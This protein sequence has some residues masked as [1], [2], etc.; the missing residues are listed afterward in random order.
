MTAGPR[1][2]DPSSETD[3]AAPEQTSWAWYALAAGLAL[4]HA[5]LAVRI[6]NGGLG[7]PISYDGDGVAV[8]A[9]A[10]TAARQGWYEFEPHLGWPHGQTYHDFPTAENLHMAVFAVL[11]KLWQ[12]VT[13]VNVYFLAGFALAAPLALRLFRAI[14]L[15]PIM[16]TVM[17]VL[18]ATAA[19][20]YWRGIPHLFLA[21]YWVL[22]PA[23]LVVWRSAR[24]EP[25]WR[26]APGRYGKWRPVSTVAAFVLLGIA[27]TYYSVFVGAL[28][29]IAAVACLVQR[30]GWR[31][32]LSPLVAGLVLVAVMLA[33]M[34]TDIAYARSL[35]ANPVG[36]TRSAGDVE[37]FGLRLT[38]L[39]LPT[40]DHWFGPARRL[41]D[42]FFRTIPIP[43]GPSLGL[44]A[45]AGLVLLAVVI[46]LRILGRGPQTASAGR[47][48]TL[49]FLTLGAIAMATVGGGS[50]TIA[51]LTPNLRGWD[52]MLI[53]VAAFA[54]A[55]LGL[56]LDSTGRSPS[57]TAIR[58]RPRVATMLALGVLAI[59]LIDQVPWYDTTSQ[60]EMRSAWES[61]RGY[62][63][64]LET[65]FGASATIA[66]LPWRGFPETGPLN[67]TADTDPLRLFVASKDGP[68]FSFGGIRGRPQADWWQPMSTRAM[69][70]QLRQLAAIGFTVVSLDRTAA[71]A[72]A[73]DQE[74]A[75]TAALG[76]AA[77]TS[78]DGRYL[79]WS[80][81]SADRQLHR[82][83]DDAAI[84]A[85]AADLTTPPM[86]Y[87]LYDPYQLSLA[88]DNP[89]DHP[90]QVSVDITIGLMP[91]LSQVTVRAPGQSAIT[92][93]GT[94]SV[95]WQTTMV[96]PPGR[97][98]VSLEVPAAQWRE[99]KPSNGPGVWLD[100]SSRLVVEDDESFAH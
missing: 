76:P 32:V 44:V 43:V 5:L 66:Q 87:P 50:E 96:L 95:R 80:L 90:Q 25:V 100:A 57:P 54:L 10:T 81:A 92:L 28:L 97:T 60:A 75:L 79:A 8:L 26:R 4:A 56:V 46:V 61:D 9:H 71:G 16:A 35:P 98:V 72:Q 58:H 69:P 67:G 38:Q 29:G 91:G 94:G 62:L 99:L 48:S 34:A 65:Q 1:S 24:A 74:A 19:Y 77:V 37:A 13:V 53:V 12:P 73:D 36:L 11:G 85:A 88:L 89:R 20:H 39:L 6:W 30:A 68:S 82:G 45:S 55:A 78:P 33:N 59:G 18:W 51:L 42:Y 23:L 83:H 17:A 22:P 14:G 70:Q 47:L 21:S 93:E 15:R 41:S 2:G 3:A 52:R 49:A 40:D 86:V 31:A 64:D 7:T 27:S 63:A 84:E